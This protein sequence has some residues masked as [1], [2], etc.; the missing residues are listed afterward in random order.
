MANKSNIFLP[1]LFYGLPN[2]ELRDLLQR[3]LLPRGEG[4]WVSHAWAFTSKVKLELL[5]VL[6]EIMLYFNFIILLI[7]FWRKILLFEH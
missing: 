4:I 2:P 3:S 1:L 7:L 6:A 5:I